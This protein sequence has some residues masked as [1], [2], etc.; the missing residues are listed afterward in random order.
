[1]REYR[2]LVG[3]FM[4]ETNT[5]SRALTEIDNFRNF[6]CFEG[7]AVLDGLRDTNNEV[8]GFIDI[9]DANHWSLVPTVA[10][11]ATPGGRVTGRAWKHFVGMIL[12]GARNGKFDGVALSLHG[13]MV[14]EDFE[15]GEGELLEQLRKV[16]GT[17]VPVAVTLDLHANVSEKMVSLADILVSYKTFP[18]V[19]M[20]ETGRKAAQLLARTMESEISP[21][22]ESATCPLLTACEGGR[23]DRGPMV[24][25]LREAV[26]LEQTPGVLDISLNA[27]FPLADTPFT[28]PRVTV[29]S[30][31]LVPEASR[32]AR[33]LIDQVW[34]HRDQQ[35]ERYFSVREAAQKARSPIT[36]SGPLVIADYSDNPGDGAYGDATNL[37]AALLEARVHCAAF[38]ALHDP[39]VARSLHRRKVGD[40]IEVS[41]GGKHDPR[42]G[43]G[44]LRVRGRIQSL[45]NGD[46]VCDGPMWKG[47]R[48]SAGDS[49]VL[50]VGDLDI[51]ITT[52]VIQAID[53]QLFIANGIDPRRKQ[54]VAVKSQQHFRAAFEPIAEEVIL[55]ESGGL[56]S[57]NF[58]QH[59]YQRVRRPIYPLDKF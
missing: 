1:M 52:H 48:Q 34:D 53:L 7:R 51:L 47:V 45:T 40:E 33:T 13:A 35:I 21:T 27:G 25:L 28:G 46:F 14:T 31:G 3:Q 41:L 6:F 8:A 23:T 58:A 2:V 49:A 54:V 55:A 24:S 19:D 9:A 56:A 10:T 18:H 43:G 11:F 16:I 12:E 50:R 22:V 30:D 17:Q 4:H 44:P 59:P 57:N 20:R 15:D 36:T 42:F 29:V 32:I 26:S 5:F 38:G 37:L 39:E